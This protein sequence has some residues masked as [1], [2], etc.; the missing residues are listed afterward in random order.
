MV[1]AVSNLEDA[2]SVLKPAMNAVGVNVDHIED[3]I[4]EAD[5]D[6]LEELTSELMTLPDRFNDQFA[7]EGWIFYD[8]IE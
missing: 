3:S 5:R 1:N 6:E 8:M 4:E 2:F 7:S